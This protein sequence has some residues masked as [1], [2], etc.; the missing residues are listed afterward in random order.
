M[1]HSMAR[2][3]DN[4][5]GSGGAYWMLIPAVAFTLLL[6]GLPF[7]YTIYLS[8]NQFVFGKDA[9]FNAGRNY[10]L[11]LQDRLFWNGLWVTLVLYGISL[12]LQ[13]AFGL[14]LG[15]LLDRSVRGRGLLRTILISP[16]VMPSVVVG[17]MWLVILDPS[18]G[19]A[20]YVLESLGLP[21]STWLAS[22]LLVVPTIA[23]IDTWQWTPFVALII[24]GGM[25]VL[26]IE[27]YEAAS[28]DGAKR[29][30]TFRY[31]TLP[32]LRPAMITAATLRS[33]DLL[34]FFDT[35]YITTQGGPSNA[36]TTLNIYAF[37]VGFEFF[38]IGYASAQMI[39]LL[40]IVFGAV[41]AFAQLRRH[42]L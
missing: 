5:P 19:A 38:D 41:M 24:L 1:G 6:I 7:L 8:L 2:A 4:A 42:A 36:S 40:A 18:I 21:R 35:I 30:Q 34:R 17:M 28:I 29:W 3:R 37:R 23:L 39:T 10:L 27:P 12:A 15:M 16:F 20:N 26:P 33:V 25:Q 32:L 14:Y 11:M 22:P 9:V 31:I 13:M